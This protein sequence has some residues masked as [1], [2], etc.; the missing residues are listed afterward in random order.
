[1]ARVW[2]AR[3]RGTGQIVALKMLLPELAENPA[4]REMFFDEAR[5]ASRVRH[6]NVCVTYEL[7]QYDNVLCLAMEWVDGPSLMRLLRPGPDHV[8]ELPRVPIHPRLVAR[9]IAETCA[10]LHAAHELV[11][12]DGR[13]LGV[14][15]RDV[16]PHNILLNTGGAIKI[17]DFGVAKALGKTSQT[18]AGQIKGKLAYMA[19]EQ[20][21]GGGVDRRSD[22]FALGCVLYELTLGVRPFQGDHDPQIMT[23]IIIGRY[24]PPSAIAPGYPPELERIIVQALG[25]EPDQRF[26][27][28]EAVRQALESYLRSSGPP[29]TAAHVSGLLRER[30]GQE[31]DARTA[32]LNGKL[33]PPRAR[34]ATGSGSG[35]MAVDGRP[36]PHDD[37]TAA[38]RRA[39][40]GLVAAVLVGAA[41]GLGVLGYL[42][43][44]WKAKPTAAVIELDAPTAA[45]PTVVPGV[46]TT[47]VAAAG[48]ADAGLVFL[49]VTPATAVIAVDGLDLPAGTA[50]VGRPADGGTLNVVVRADKHDETVVLVDSQTS[51]DLD[52]SL[53]PSVRKGSAARV[54]R[55]ASAVAVP[56]ETPPNPYE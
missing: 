28:A 41:L 2:A 20:L 55:D 9:I 6:P 19:P 40:L 46:V 52:I 24:E 22:V 3:V 29:V 32:A 45:A 4:F 33:P 8:E 50:A 47:A 10:G 54:A 39:V 18:V 35:A 15:H 16:S 56:I 27:S 14:V 51:S 37:R 48:A 31:I 23:S 17:T 11:G 42:R 49:H 44:S 12:D 38:E 53:V 7:G 5:I 26:P 30:C 34:A 43:A 21:M 36:A 25:N 1:M 13:S